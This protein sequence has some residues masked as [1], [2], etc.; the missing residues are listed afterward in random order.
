MPYSHHRSR[1]QCAGRAGFTLLEL[2]IVVGIIAILI[3]LGLSV[4]AKVL[5]T[6]KVEA[7]KQTLRTL[8]EALT[9]YI[10]A[11]GGNPAPF[12]VDPR[13]GN[14]GG[15]YLVPAIDGRCEST[16]QMVNSVACF[17][18]QCRAVPSAAAA[19]KHLDSK[20]LREYSPDAV[21]GNFVADAQPSL[22][23]AFDA[24]GHPIR[25]VHP[26]F[27][28]LVPNPPT[29]YVALKATGPVAGGELLVPGAGPQNQ[30]GVQRVRRNNTNSSASASPPDADSDGGLNPATRP[31]FY[32][33][34]PDGDPSTLEDNVY[35]TV[36]RVQKSS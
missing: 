15:K 5:G 4:G 3:V 9:S 7:T 34:G 28:G 33:A 2:L 10:Q 18:F 6:G 21:G 35:L 31:Y 24:W 23:T 8:D 29:T 17:M 36:P 26:F 30:F 22:P 11:T 14:N 16:G 12:I 25:Y 20:F 32:S 27:K 13:E 19:M 1:T